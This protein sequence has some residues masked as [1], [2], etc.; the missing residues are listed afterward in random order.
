MSSRAD[1]PP[2]HWVEIDGQRIA[3]YVLEPAGTPVGEVV[4]CHG[5]PW[6]SAVWAP[7]ATH[8]A[9]TRRVYLWDMPGYG[10]SIT[11]D[12]APV[13]L[14][15]QRRR[16]ASL[17]RFWGLERPDVVAHDIGG[18]VALGAHLLEGVPLASL[19]LLDV[20]ALDPWGSGFF[21]LVTQHHDAFAALPSN[22]HA[23]LVREYIS[24]ASNHALSADTVA[25]LAAPWCTRAGQRAFY[26][27][28]AEL[29]PAHTRAIVERLGEVAC[30][31][32]IGW[33]ALDPWIPAAQ[34]AELAALLP[35]SADVLSVPGVGHLGPLEAPEVFSSDI[36]T[37]LDRVR[38]G[39]EV[40]R[41]GKS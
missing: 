27:Q 39:A 19:Y 22:L 29:R 16:F 18:A 5:T 4:F 23:A 36:A 9:L 15:T 34:A 26:H 7:V 32:R 31:V 10:A 40:L 12:P 11:A 3:S 25:E 20:V 14:I 24:D 13:D 41:S 8:L 28:I 6:S 38:N 21:R 17:V 30:P 33:G 35:G 1:H 2:P 37:W